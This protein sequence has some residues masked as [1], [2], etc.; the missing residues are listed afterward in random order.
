MVR[1]GFRVHREKLGEH[2]VG[3]QNFSVTIPSQSTPRLRSLTVCSQPNR[4][5]VREV[6]PCGTSQSV[7]G[8]PAE[9]AD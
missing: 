8:V 9:I 1:V 5:M 4:L 3:K 2:T 7:Q 6:L